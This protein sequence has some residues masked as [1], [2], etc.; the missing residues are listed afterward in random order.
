MLPSFQ[1]GHQV[2]ES[3]AVPHRLV[4]PLFFS[5]S[6]WPPLRRSSS[7]SRPLRQEPSSSTDLA[8]GGQARQG[9]DRQRQRQEGQ[10]GQE[11]QRPWQW[12]LSSGINRG[13]YT[14]SRHWP[15]A[16]GTTPKRDNSG[17]L[18]GGPG[19]FYASAC[20]TS[21]FYKFTLRSDGRRTIS[22]F[23]QAETFCSFRLRWCWGHLA[24]L[25]PLGL[26]LPWRVHRVQRGS[27]SL[28]AHALP[29]A[30]PVE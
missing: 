1:L 27:F 13:A 12:Q 16:I 14:G 23:C 22:F 24:G 30:T 6:F 26:S 28:N 21:S 9:Q 15:V 20:R 5:P 3:T 11:G 10:K 17:Q 8:R 4:P 29:M 25:E 7:W 18:A 2:H 19:I